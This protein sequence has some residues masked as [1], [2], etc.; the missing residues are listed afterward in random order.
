MI[1]RI[2]NLKAGDCILWIDV[3]AHVNGRLVHHVCE[4]NSFEE[5]EKFYYDNFY[6]EYHIP[7]HITYHK[8]DRTTLSLL[9]KAC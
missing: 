2:N 3:L 7:I 5:A 1:P 8:F 9:S 4:G 6:R